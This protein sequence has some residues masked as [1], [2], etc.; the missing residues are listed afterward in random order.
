[1]KSFS[2]IET[3]GL[4]QDLVAG[5]CE[6]KAMLQCA[7]HCVLGYTQMVAARAWAG[8]NDEQQGQR[9]SHRAGA[10][11]ANMHEAGVGNSAAIIRH[12]VPDPPAGAG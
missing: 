5:R 11:R 12:M 10:V 8:R 3:V 1:M 9:R 7:V 2:L 4:E 6:I